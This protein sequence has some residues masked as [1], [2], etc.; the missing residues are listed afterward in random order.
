M[1]TLTFQDTFIRADSGTVGND[2]VDSSAVFAIDNN[3]LTT[4]G[5]V[6]SSNYRLRR[7]ANEAS[8]D[9]LVSL[10]VDSIPSGKTI[11]VAVRYT[12]SPQAFYY[13]EVSRTALTIR[14]AGETNLAQTMWSG[15]SISYRCSVAVRDSGG[16][17]YIEGRVSLAT[18][19]DTVIQSVTYSEAVAVGSGAGALLMPG[20][21]AVDVQDF[22]VYDFS[23]NS[24]PTFGVTS[25]GCAASSQ[26]YSPGM[27]VSQIYSPGAAAAQV[28]C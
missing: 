17:T 24:W 19:P 15:G 5:G 9:Q 23:D 1:A 6:D 13:L 12:H 20:A 11:R 21:G 26:V 7:P 4:D 28:G 3:R 2:W 16:T 18:D 14:A 27:S 10:I 22:R 8:T 25:G